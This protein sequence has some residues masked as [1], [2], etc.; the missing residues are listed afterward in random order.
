MIK[1]KLSTLGWSEEDNK[2]IK[3]FEFKGN[4]KTISFVNT[5]YWLANKY[6]HHPDMYLTFNT[7][8]VILTTHDQGNTITNKDY[9]LAEN[10]EKL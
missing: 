1:K 8:K 3:T 7:C 5:V 2:L 4:L 10:I 6:N 9:E